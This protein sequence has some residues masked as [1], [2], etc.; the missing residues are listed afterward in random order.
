MFKYF[1]PMLVR[2]SIG[3]V[4][5]AVLFITTS[6]LVAWTGPASAPP[7]SN[8]SAPINVGTTNQVK[9]AG[10][11]VN[12]LAVFGNAIISGTSRYLNFN[13]T[14]G[15]TGYGI[16]DNNG[17][18]EF[19]NASGAWAPIASSSSTAS[20][21]HGGITY[22]IPGTYS[23]TV[24]A[25]IT[26]IK[27]TAV[28]AGGGGGGGQSSCCACGGAGGTGAVAIGWATDLTPGQAVTVQVGAG[29]AGGGSARNGTAGTASSFGP[30]VVAGGGGLGVQGGGS[31]A[32]GAGGT[33]SGSGLEWS[34][35]GSTGGTGTGGSG[36][37]QKIGPSSRGPF[38]N[39]YGL[40][41]AGAG[42]GGQS[43]SSGTG[44]EQGFV[45]LEW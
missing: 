9:N 6:V 23:F 5:A 25:G 39:T 44:G 40:S 45:F 1:G 36:C 43:G 16:R 33:G 42:D 31:R 28:G 29:G 10:L 12:A 7:N 22:A 13:T 32:G 30:Y 4:L 27:V 8:V 14:V 2:G 26:S 35:S 11:S 41:Y 18:M 3:F 34:M 37:T 38:T 24:P 15:D 19:K 21:T 17:A 20:P